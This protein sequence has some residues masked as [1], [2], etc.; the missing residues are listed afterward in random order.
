MRARR[1]ALLC[2]VLAGILLLLAA[3]ATLVGGVIDLA[4]GHVEARGFVAAAGSFF[5]E[6][7]LGALM[8]AFAAIGSHR[9]TDVRMG[10]G[11]AMLLFGLVTWLFVGDSPLLLLGGLFALLSGIFLFLERG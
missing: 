8:I 10:A 5:V 2:G 4:L 9:S 3:L 7:I 6:G 1:V 11:V